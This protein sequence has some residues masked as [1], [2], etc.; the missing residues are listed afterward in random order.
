[1]NVNTVVESPFVPVL[2]LFYYLQR[3]P[4]TDEGVRV[5]VEVSEAL[6]IVDDVCPSAPLLIGDIREFRC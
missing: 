3:P 5:M 6:S 2:G 4:C 1:M